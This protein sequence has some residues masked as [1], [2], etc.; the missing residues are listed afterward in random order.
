[1]RLRVATTR[2]LQRICSDD[3]RQN[4]TERFRR[5][6]ARGWLSQRQ[7]GSDHAD[8]ALAAARRS[9]MTRTHTGSLQSPGCLLFPR[10]TNAGM[11]GRIGAWPCC[12]PSEIHEM[13]AGWVPLSGARVLSDPAA[14]GPGGNLPGP[15]RDRDGVSE[16]CVVNPVHGDFQEGASFVITH[17]CDYCACFAGKQAG[18]ASKGAV[19][20][21]FD[22]ASPRRST[23]RW[24]T[25]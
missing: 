7:S 21:G 16:L 14:M 24:A 6:P 11:A 20:W 17:A 2:I 4:P 8:A 19:L 25:A 9:Y 10:H 23:T 5:A 18:K 15:P 13:G 1:M 3:G 12:W 22:F